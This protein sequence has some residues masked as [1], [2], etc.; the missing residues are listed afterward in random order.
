MVFDSLF[1]P[2]G[3]VGLQ[4]KEKCLPGDVLPMEILVTTE[5][6]IKPRELRAE[7]VGQETYYVTETH[8][9]SKGNI[10][11]HTVP[12]T[13]TFASTIQT[14]EELPDLLKGV[15][16]KWSHSVQLPAD[17]PHTCQGKVVNIRWTLKA[18]LDVPKRGDMS[19]EN[20][21]TVLCLSPQITDMS[22]SPSE[23]IFG[24][25][26]LV[27]KAPQI[28]YAG[29][30]LK[31]QLTLQVKE[32]MS[33]RSIRIELV[34]VEEAGVRKSDEVISTIQIPGAESFNPN[35]SPSFDFSLDIPAEAPPTTFGKHSNLR[36]KIRAVLDR[37]MKTDFNVEQE[38][39]VYN[40]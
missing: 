20:S 15:E 13:E 33:I 30:P 36:W 34:Q 25:V 23:K 14:V 11:T 22:F 39:I 9:D 8:R 7:L 28:A 27:L 26:I 29:H 24:E 6:V 5:E 2:K 38:L 35:E 4:S 10:R 3:K 17:A 31:G 37:K 18:V 1:K 12:R 40:N 21:L 19:Q 32:K 16:K